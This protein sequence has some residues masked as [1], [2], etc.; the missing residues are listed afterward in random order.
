[1]LDKRGEVIESCWG[2]YGDDGFKEAKHQAEESVPD[3]PD[4]SLTDS[5]ALDLLVSVTGQAGLNGKFDART[6]ANI[7]QTIERTGRKIG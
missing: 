3:K 1:M 7:I 4:N 2:F 6:C 5:A